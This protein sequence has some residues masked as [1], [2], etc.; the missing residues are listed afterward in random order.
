MNKLKKR[1][2]FAIVLLITIIVSSMFVK[3]Y[4]EK[5]Y[6]QRQAAN[7]NYFHWAEI[8][9]MIF[10]IEKTNFTKEGIQKIYPYINAKVYS[11]EEYL[12]PVFGG[13]SNTSSFLKTYYNS[14]ALDISASQKFDSE[15]LQLA[16]DLF[17]EAT[18]ELKEISLTI[19]EMAEDPQNRLELINTDS[20][21]YKQAYK[22]TMEYS[23]EYSER[24]KNFY[25]D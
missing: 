17:E 14:L 3:I 12:S 1:Y 16:I 19:L 24:I 8:Y 9:N 10:E 7:H 11:S 23:K 5:C 4:N 18:N 22:M 20:E 2:I 21:I 6:W 25:T 15:K 13:A